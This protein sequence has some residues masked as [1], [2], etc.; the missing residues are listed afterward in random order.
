M[1]MQT[2]QRK[3]KDIKRLLSNYPAGNSGADPALVLH[4]YLTA[5][6]DHPAEVVEDAVTAFI[7]GKV[8]GH[9]GRFA[10]KAPELAQACRMIQ[11]KAARNRYLAGI[12]TPRL[13]PPDIVKTDEE[14]AR[15]RA[16][17]EETIAR[18]SAVEGGPDRG[19]EAARKAT[20]ERLARHDAIFADDFVPVDG[21][22]GRISRSLAKT[23]G[24][25][26]P[27]PRFTAGDPDGDRDVA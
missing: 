23:I 20:Q 5:V 1:P 24:Y 21:G 22:V 16:L 27:E 17:M 13:P 4:N 2:P 12:H 6:E 8:P 25:A 14:R 10:P 9:D 11:E 15:A 18:L 3:L 26:E 7:K 19:E